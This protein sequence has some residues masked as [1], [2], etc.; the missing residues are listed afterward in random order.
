MFPI[1]RFHSN[2]SAVKHRPYIEYVTKPAAETNHHLSPG[3]KLSGKFASIDLFGDI[4]AI[5]LFTNVF[6]HDKIEI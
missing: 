6:L 4:S 1:L 3:S 5:F 2:R